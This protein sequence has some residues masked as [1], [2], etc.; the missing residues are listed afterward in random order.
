L[1][2]IAMAAG[3]LSPVSRVE[4]AVWSPTDNQRDDNQRDDNQRDDNQP[5]DDQRGDDKQGDADDEAAALRAVEAA[6]TM[7]TIDATSQPTPTLL[8]RVALRLR[9]D[10]YAD[11]AD[12]F[13]RQ[14]SRM[15][16]EQ[17]VNGRLRLRRPHVA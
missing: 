17:Y 16:S 12:K 5:S 11:Q 7:L 15:L 10:G 6:L 13:F 2:S 4:F 8:F 14:S 1:E 9:R 3:T